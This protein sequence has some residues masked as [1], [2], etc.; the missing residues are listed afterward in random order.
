[1]LAVDD[2]AAG[3][4]RLEAFL[5]GLHP[6]PARDV[7]NVSA[8]AASRPAARATSARTAVSFGGCVEMDRDRP[9]A[10]GVVDDTTATDGIEDFRQPVE[11]VARAFRAR[12]PAAPPRSVPTRDLQPPQA[13]S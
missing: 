8:F 13:R 1:M 10:A 7:S 4:D 12:L 9:A 11:Q 3:L 6:V 5:A 2:E